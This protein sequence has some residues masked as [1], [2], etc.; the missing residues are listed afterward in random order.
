MC[1]ELVVAFFFIQILFAIEW[2]GQQ[3]WQNAE[4]YGPLNLAGMEPD[5]F[6]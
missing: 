5:G 6:F 3:A 4:Y 1:V 2:R